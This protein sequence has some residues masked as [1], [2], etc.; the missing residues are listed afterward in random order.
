M[1]LNRII[2]NS[3]LKQIPTK[4]LVLIY[5]RLKEDEDD[6]FDLG[7]SLTSCHEVAI[8]NRKEGCN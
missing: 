4:T 5:A 3:A 8:P 2:S 1:R 7:M 6:Q